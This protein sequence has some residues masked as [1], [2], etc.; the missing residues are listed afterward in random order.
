MLTDPR[1]RNIQALMGVVL[2]TLEDYNDPRTQGERVGTA[3]KPSSRPPGRLQCDRLV[4][5]CIQIFE[6]ATSSA[7]A[8]LDGWKAGQFPPSRRGPYKPRRR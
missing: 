2:Q 8:R 4:A 1:L 7:T 5:E 6:D 3:G